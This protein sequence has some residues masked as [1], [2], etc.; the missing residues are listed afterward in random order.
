MRRGLKMVAVLGILATFVGT[1]QRADGQEVTIQVENLQPMGGF[2]FTP[3]W[4]AIHDGGFE[5]FD[6]G[7]SAATN[8]G[9]TEIAEF[10]DTSVI[11]GRFGMQQPGGVQTTFAEPNG[12]PVFSPGESASTSL[13]VMDPM[14]NRFLSYASMLV[15]SNDLFVGNDDALELFD[16]DG[17]FNG[18][19]T[20]NLFGSSVYDNGSELNNIFD[21]PAF[22][23][24]QDAADG[25]DENGVIRSL[26]SDAGDGPYLASIIGVTT[27]PGGVIT[28]TFDES[29]LIGR[30]T[31]TPEPGTAAILMVGLLAGMRRRR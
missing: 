22:V 23:Q 29:S 5:V 18:P 2:S 28:N 21:G 16:A 17:N 7:T 13:N 9:I 19:F 27:A 20:I 6:S 10:G 3:F 1:T 4:L 11:T 30:I 15:P 25:V 12:P 8:A 31:V 26:F 14:T 24:G